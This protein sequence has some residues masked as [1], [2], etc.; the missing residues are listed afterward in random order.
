[1]PVALVVVAQLA[2]C[3]TLPPFRDDAVSTA[4]VILN[5]RCEL[6]EAVW[7]R[8]GTEWV[9]TWNAGLTF[10]LEVQH[11]GGIDADTSWVFPMFQSAT[12]TVAPVLGFSGQA[13]RKEN[14]NFNE[15]L[16]FLRDDAKL[17]CGT[18]DPD[19]YARLGGEI[20]FADLLDRVGQS[21]DK[22]NIQPKDLSYNLDFVIKMNGNLTPKFSLI[23]VGR[24]GRFTGFAKWTGSHSDTQTL[25][26]VLTP[27]AKVDKGPECKHKL[28]EGK[29]PIPVYQVVP[30]LDADKGEEKGARFLE[31]RIERRGPDAALSRRP[32]PADG[33]RGLTP[34]D[35]ERIE[36]AQTRNLLD[37]IEGELRKG[38]IGD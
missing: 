13:T 9:H 18:Q 37:G 12:F 11:T 3:A 1:M 30:E 33:R 22:A 36:R 23:P 29:C 34:A 14:I 31:R 19:R 5:I 4:D 20:G 2:G 38:G 27:P 17:R 28:V 25:K 16:E 6:R 10:G 8:P 15:K 32:T 21:M 35:E 26:L 24:D 7:S